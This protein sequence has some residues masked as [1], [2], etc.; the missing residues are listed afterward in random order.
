MKDLSQFIRELL[1]SND[2]VILPGFGGFIGN[3]TPARID[4]ESNTFHP[5]VKAISFNSKLSHNDGLLI[6]TISAKKGIGY[7]DAKRMVE[8]YVGGLKE[9]LEKGQRIHLDSIGHFQLNGDGGLQFEPDGDINYLLDSYGL[10]A[11]TREPVQDYDIS[12]AV[13]SRG[14][15]DPVIIANRRRMIWRAAVAVPFILAIIVVPLKKDFFKSNAGLNPLAKVEF[16][17]VRSAQEELFREMP[18]AKAQLTAEDVSADEAIVTDD[19]GTDPE[20]L[21]PVQQ[22]LEPVQLNYH[23]IAGSFKDVENAQRLL[24][25]ITERGYSPEL[26]RADNGYY[27]VSVIS[28][29]TMREASEERKRLTGKYPEIWILKK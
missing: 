13:L 5:P 21:S 27:R 1:F 20:E 3:Y 26:F 11:F 12:R 22:P 15:R 24:N 10:T 19:A 2:C 9:R 4:H 28:F 14:E 18:A 8:D 23:L 7:A 29:A 6:G 17:E 25:E 16:E